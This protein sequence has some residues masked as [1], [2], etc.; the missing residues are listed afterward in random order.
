MVKKG[1]KLRT[2]GSV[3]PSRYMTKL[4]LFLLL[5]GVISIGVAPLHAGVIF[6]FNELGDI[7]YSLSG[8]PYV[9][10]PNGVAETD[11]SG[12]VAGKV[13]VYNLTKALDPYEMQNGDVP[14][15]GT[16]GG[17][18]AD[19]RFIDSSG[20]ADDCGTVKCYMIFYV[21][22]NEGLPADVGPISTSFLTTQTPGAV[23]GS[24]GSFSY[25]ADELI[26]YEGTIV[27]EPAPVVMLSFGM[28]AFFFI[29]RRSKAK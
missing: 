21:F 8:N 10:L 20:G 6:Q 25:T 5:A 17:L 27:P 22:D 19:L 7:E 14:I 11:P 1:L 16:G 2:Y 24:N 13:L 28:A 29:H 18:I 26:T 4:R 3:G 15:G 9:A 12:A 23:L